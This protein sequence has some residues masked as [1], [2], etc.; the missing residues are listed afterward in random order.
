MFSDS[1]QFIE[2]NPQLYIYCILLHIYTIKTILI[3][4]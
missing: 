3:Q 2:D 4:A 1:K